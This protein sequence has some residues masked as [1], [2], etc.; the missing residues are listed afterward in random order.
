MRKFLLPILMFLFCFG[1]S[2]QSVNKFVE[3]KSKILIPVPPE[4]KD[5]LVE[6]LNLYIEFFNRKDLRNLYNLV[7]A[8]AKKGLIEN[9]FLKSAK[10]KSEGKFLFFTVSKIRK[11]DKDEYADEPKPAI[12]EGEKW[13]VNGCMKFKDNKGK[14]KFYEKGFDVW[15]TNNEWYISRYGFRLADG[16]YKECRVEP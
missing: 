6:R 14:I 13:F 3:I 12:G 5:R 2:A 9:D 11:A 15:L 8:R 10:I 1:A 16:G 7:S 4:N